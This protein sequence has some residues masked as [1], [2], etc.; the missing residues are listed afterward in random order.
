MLLHH[1]LPG[2]R[3]PRPTDLRDRHPPR[4]F[5]NVGGTSPSASFAATRNPRT[6]AKS[7]TSSIRGRH[8]GGRRGRQRS[9]RGNTS[10]PRNPAPRAAFRPFKRRGRDSNPRW[11]LRPTT[12]FETVPDARG[13]W[14]GAGVLRRAGCVRSVCDRVRYASFATTQRAR[15]ASCDLAQERGRGAL[16]SPGRIEATCGLPRLHQQGRL[17]APGAKPGAEPT[18]RGAEHERRPAAPSEAL[19]RGGTAAFL[20][21]ARSVRVKGACSD[22]PGTCPRDRSLAREVHGGQ[23]PLLTSR[24]NAADLS[25]LDPCLATFLWR[26]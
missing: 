1:R 2:R 15:A 23:R 21:C 8:S 10:T 24:M 7:G 14:R 5:R 20:L 13:M 12:V 9:A 3:L 6:A 17:V 4:Q 11:T 16:Q 25:P 22:S 26:G 18:K 19:W